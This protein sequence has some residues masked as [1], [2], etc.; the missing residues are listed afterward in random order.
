MLQYMNQQTTYK[1]RTHDQYRSWTLDKTPQ[2]LKT[3]SVL[4]DTDGRAA[5]TSTLTLVRM[6][7]VAGR[8]LC[9][10]SSDV[11]ISFLDN[12]SIETIGTDASD[13]ANLDDADYELR[14]PQPVLWL[15]SCQAYANLSWRSEYHC[16]CKIQYQS[17]H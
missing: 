13:I 9:A 5:C 15:H 2:S 10:D 14:N 11:V 7:A 3:I 8:A 1:F 4:Q 17:L 16:L 6:G 12:W